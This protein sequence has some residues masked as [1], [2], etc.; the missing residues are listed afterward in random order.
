M[1]ITGTYIL[2]TVC[3][4]FLYIVHFFKLFF[5]YCYFLFNY[6]IFIL[7]LSV[8]RC[9]YK[10]CVCV[11]DGMLFPLRYDRNKL[12]LKEIHNVQYVSC[13]NPTSGSFTI[14]PRLQ[15]LTISVNSIPDIKHSLS[16][17]LTLFTFT[18]WKMF[19]IASVTCQ[20]LSKGLM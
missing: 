3:C 7:L 15:V 8:S 9:A 16:P 4:L 17:S 18:T 19:H 1:Y 10:A 6:S 13:M 12:Q 11:T 2:Y 5:V 20:S 14:N